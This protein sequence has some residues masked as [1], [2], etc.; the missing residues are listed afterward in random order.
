MTTADIFRD[1]ISAELARG[2]PAT[3]VG[4]DV[5]L[6]REQVIDSLGIIRLVALVQSE[7]GVY[8]DDEELLL[9]NVSQRRSRPRRPAAGARTSSTYRCALR[10]PRP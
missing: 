1:F 8:V 4:D 9:Q 10:Y 6:V 3:E 7:F 5:A 2:R